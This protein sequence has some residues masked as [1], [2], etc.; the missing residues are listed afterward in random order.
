MQKQ[1]IADQRLWGRVPAAAS[2]IV[3]PLV[4]VL[5]GWNPGWW[6]GMVAVVVI[7][8]LTVLLPPR[9]T[10]SIY[11]IDL[12]ERLLRLPLWLG[13]LLPVWYLSVQE[14]RFPILGIPVAGAVAVTAIVWLLTRALS[15]TSRLAARRVMARGSTSGA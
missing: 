11:L 13:W 15:L 1:L 2:G 3:W 14:P 7:A 5:L 6:V 9:L 10:V 12:L 4:V 8:I